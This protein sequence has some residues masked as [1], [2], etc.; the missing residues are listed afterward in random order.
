MPHSPSRRRSPSR[1]SSHRRVNDFG[2]A[3]P[4]KPKDDEL[5]LF[6]DMQKTEIE[7]FLLEPSE[8]FDE[9]ISKLSF[10]PDVKLGINVPARGE[11]HDLLKVDGDKNDY[12]WLLTPPETPLFRS[13]D[14]EEEQFVG[15]ASRGRAQSKGMQIS[16]PSTMDNAQRSSRSSASP[17]RF[18]LSPRS[19]ARTKSPI[20]ASR[21]S[22]PLSVQPPTPSRR[23]STP[24]AAKISTLPQR[25]ASPVSRRMSAGSS[26]SALNGTRG[27]SPVKANHRSSSTKPQGWQSNDP[28]FSYNAPPNLRTSLPD[29]SVSRSRGGSPTS[30]SGLDTGSRGRRQSMSPTPTRRASSSHSI[31][32]DRLSTHSK[33]SATSSGDDDLDSMQSISIGYSS[34]P[35]VK[36]SLAVMKT[37]SIASSKKLSKNFSP[38]SAPKWSFDS[39]VWLMD[40]R[41][42]PQDRFRP[43]L[44][45]VPATTFGAGKINNVHKLHQQDLIG[46]WDADDG[47]RV[48]EDIFMFDKL[49]ELNEETSY[50]KSTKYVEDSPI[51]VKYVKSDKHDFDMER[52]AANQTPYDGADSS[53]VGHGEM[54]TCSRC[55]MSFN[56]MD[57]DGKGDSCGECSSKVEGFSADHMLWTSVAHQHG[58]KI[59]NSEPCVESEPSI[60]PDSVDYSKHA[61]LGHQTVNNEPLADCTEKCPPGQSMVDTDEDMLLGQEVVNYE[62][63]MR[64]YHE[65]DSLVENE[66][67]V[68]FSRSSISNHQQIEPTSAEH[69]PYR[70][71]MDTCNHGLPPCLNESDCQHNEAVSET[72]F[73]DNS[74]QLGS[75]IHPFPKV[76]SAE[77]AGISVLLHQKSSSNKW[78]V[79]EGSALAATNIVCSEP[80]YTRD[81]INMMKRSFGRD[82]S[83][84]SSIDLGSS[85]QSDA[86]FERRSSSKKGDFEKAQPSSTMSRQSIASVSDMSVS[87]SSA[88]LCHQTDAV[89]DTY[90]RIDTLESSA[91]RTVVS[92][93]ED[94][95]SKDALS[96]ALECLSTARPIVNDDIPVDLN[97][98]SFDRSSETEDVISMGRMADN[99]HSTTN[100]CL[101]EMEEPINVQESSA[102]EGSCMLKTDEDTSDTVQCC[103]VGTPEYPSEENLDNLIMQSEAVQDSIE[104]HILDDCCVSAISEEDVLVS[105]T[106]TS[107]I[108]LPNGEKSP[109]AV[110]GSRK[111]IQRCF[112]LEEATDTILLCSSIVHDL[113][114]KAATIALEHEQES[115]RHRPTVTIVGKPIPDEDDFLKLPHRR[116]PNRKVKRK[117]LEGETTTITET[118]EKESIAE[119]PS[120]ARSAS[121]IT[122]A[123]VNMKPPKLESKCNCVIM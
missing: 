90:S 32:R 76:E 50:N 35:A 2:N 57:S 27:A 93:G 39:A 19:M 52:W 58:N 64:P 28:A 87:G 73:G 123:S 54:A 36:K 101:S 112:T 102:A 25:S 53:Q 85:R 66:D 118:A 24:P 30:F 29:R 4:A 92:A 21:A 88:S 41:K 80:Y 77:G 103:L 82:N 11:S 86:H 45:S 96:N 94:G 78:P 49:D 13:L 56:V 84:A 81:G 113:A 100:M 108:E 115:E 117:R 7:N 40:H 62:E 74:H 79:M 67:D 15:Q 119:D 106:G 1:E 44:S 12:E 26:G 120:P 91:S 111:Q 61:S 114:Y 17:N 3:L 75:T 43:L 14:D 51:R 89:E 69:G 70:G 116:T 109:Q 23:P 121:G 60:A 48:H 46:E 42:G 110:E 22:P 95:S 122:R 68:S 65:S 47:L 6:A 33:A 63:N 37:R 59:V 20:S 8:D 97:S 5:T 9:S 83:S 16:R 34:S 104:E 10:F 107:I 38:I 31:E 18:S 71:Q 55:G 99:D 105:R 98:S 72:A